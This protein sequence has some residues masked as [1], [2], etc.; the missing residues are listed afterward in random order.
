MLGR[1]IITGFRR[2][3][4][5][6]S[7]GRDN[8]QIGSN[9]HDVNIILGRT[10][11]VVEGL[12]A[13]VHRGAQSDLPPSQLLD[14]QY[15]V[16]PFRGREHELEALTAWLE[17]PSRSASIK[18]LSG[19]G[20]QGKTRLA[21]RFASD[22]NRKGWTV[23]QAV[24]RVTHLSVSVA[25]TT[26]RLDQPALL[27]VDYADRWLLSRLVGLIEEFLYEER[28]TTV[29]I[30]LLGRASEPIWKDLRADL[31]RG[32][33]AFSEHLSLGP[34]A[35]AVEG[36]TEA[37]RD[38]V[39]AFAEWLCVSVPNKIRPPKDITHPEYGSALT[40]QMSALAE[41]CAIRDNQDKPR[42]TDVSEFLIN[43]ERRYWNRIRQ[44]FI[45]DGRIRDVTRTEL[46]RFALVA[47][48]IGPVD[49]TSIRQI[50]QESGLFESNAPYSQIIDVHGAIYPTANAEDVSDENLAMPVRPD[51]LGEDLIGTAL[52]DKA[53]FTAFEKIAA[54]AVDGRSIRRMLSAVAAASTRHSAAA[55]L[56]IASFRCNPDLP[57]YSTP[58]VF[59]A[60]TE[61]AP[62]ELLLSVY[63]SLRGSSVD[64]NRAAWQM[65]RR[66]LNELGQESTPEQRVE[67]LLEVSL[68][69]S[70]I[71]EFE[72]S[73]AA[74]TQAVSIGRE[75]TAAT[76]DRL[77]AR[78]LNTLSLSLAQ[79]G[80][81]E[82]ALEPADQAAKLYR[83]L[84]VK[85]PPELTNYA[86]ALAHLAV[87]LAR[88]NRPKAAIQHITEA[89]RIH[90]RLAKLD[91][92]QF[93]PVLATSLSILAA[94][95]HDAGDPQGALSAIRKS[96]AIRRKLS[97]AA[98]LQYLLDLTKALAN[99]AQFLL[100]ANKYSEAHDT[101]QEAVESARKLVEFDQDAY[102]PML[103][104]AL[105]SFGSS[106]TEDED[107]SA[108]RA[109]KEA[110][111]ILRRLTIRYPDVYLPMLCAALNNFA[112]GLNLA[113]NGADA[114]AATHEAVEIT[115]TI[116]HRKPERTSEQLALS[117]LTYARVR[118]KLAV[119][120]DDALS[121]AV[122]SAHLLADLSARFPELFTNHWYTSLS[123]CADILEQQ[124][125]AGLSEEFRSLIPEARPASKRAGSRTKKGTPSKRRQA[126][127]RP[128]GPADEIAPGHALTFRVDLHSKNGLPGLDKSPSLAKILQIMENTEA[129]GA[130]RMSSDPSLGKFDWAI[131]SDFHSDGLRIGDGDSMV[132]YPVALFEFREAAMMINGNDGRGYEGQV[133]SVCRSG[134]AIFKPGTSVVP[135]AP[136]WRLRMEGAGTHL[137]D[138]EGGLWASSHAIPEPEWRTSAQSVPYVIVLFGVGLGVAQPIGRSAADYDSK[139]RADELRY[140]RRFGFVAAGLV[141]WESA[142]GEGA[143]QLA[144]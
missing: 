138:N 53:I 8:I 88:T 9:V 40:L 69:S 72:A 121:A 117:L 1:R 77:L 127:G 64:I 114:L 14:A 84:V 30:L 102:A 32:E 19:P 74:A 83:V 80:D 81:H 108:A 132:P 100:A 12:N 87:C 35:R 99:C 65:A 79:A 13:S 131:E 49:E 31:D 43:H 4:K 85:H 59:A 92:E 144:G 96:V 54:S 56:L 26:K 122:Q 76:G 98:P 143:V 2:G 124:G 105:N 107:G 126:E 78:T 128:E 22:A 113:R 42:R 66:L 55:E 47:T 61:H 51:R 6:N 3:N 109:F 106:V 67:L 112:R 57:N 50:C 36:R 110:I 136:G 133:A 95:L 86:S 37:Y 5:A 101:A 46:E 62:Y 142:A 82:A 130:F 93:D 16:V 20:G 15:Q 7:V 135:V 73:V 48:L 39:I 21:N 141:R 139:S 123:T 60:L 119:N 70:V 118:A 91:P 45:D 125:N 120:L 24:E 129:E 94:R 68:R 115:R 111:A 52:S 90:G 17:D 25:P 97:H 71:G 58:D 75:M 63:H 44:S 11:Y 140:A 104:L 27:V 28:R 29:R 134:F 103:A 137:Y 23:A 34:L 116:V 33:V 89:V 10:D 38:A 41:V 18:L